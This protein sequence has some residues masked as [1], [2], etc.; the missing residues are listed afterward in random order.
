MQLFDTHA[1][2]DQT[3]FDADRVEVIA[4]ARKAGVENI[5]A[6]GISADTSAACVAWAVCVAGRLR[7]RKN[8]SSTNCTSCSATG[9]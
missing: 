1:H 9:R 4:R 2:L 5:I 7:T 6:I 8:N 3:E